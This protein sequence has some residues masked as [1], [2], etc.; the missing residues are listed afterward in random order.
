MSADIIEIQITGPVASGKSAI[1]AT[2]RK[3]LEQHHICVAVLDRVE[4][5]N[6]SSELG[7]CEPHEAPKFED[8]VVVMRENSL[9]RA[10]GEVEG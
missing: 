10:K 2:I 8:C 4:R 7:D 3:T 5:Y 6:P 1:F 9:P